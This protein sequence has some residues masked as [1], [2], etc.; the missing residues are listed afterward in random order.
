LVSVS[1]GLISGLI[2][3][4][5]SVSAGYF[6]AEHLGR[7]RVEGVSIFIFVKKKSTKKAQKKF[8]AEQLGSVK[9]VPVFG[10]FN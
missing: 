4:L 2:S 3:G 9:K 6:S 10:H 1:A 8:L 7:Q 5:V